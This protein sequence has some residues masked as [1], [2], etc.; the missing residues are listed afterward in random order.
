M[1]R[2]LITLRNRS[3][4]K[5]K[6]YALILLVSLAVACTSVPFFGGGG[7]ALDPTKGGTG[8]T[9]KLVEII[10]P[11]IQAGTNF[12]EMLM[13]TALIASIFLKP[14]RLAVASLLVAFYGY[15]EGFFRKEKIN[16]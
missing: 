8:T 12:L 13:I 2:S 11:V 14:V 15:L 10:P 3:M 4:H 16:E 9:N 1:R 7:D 6:L 5:K